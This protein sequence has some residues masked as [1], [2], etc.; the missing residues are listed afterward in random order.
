MDS[1]VLESFGGPRQ[2]MTAYLFELKKFTRNL[3]EKY[4]TNIYSNDFDIL[5][6]G[7]DESWGHAGLSNDQ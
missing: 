3:N 4:Q 1:K 2:Q 5:V 7:I 6:R